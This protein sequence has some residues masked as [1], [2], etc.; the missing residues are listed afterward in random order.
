MSY[1]QFQYLCGFTDVY[2]SGGRAL[3]DISL[4]ARSR[5]TW[6]RPAPVITSSNM[7]SGTGRSGFAVQRDCLQR[8]K[9]SFAGLRLPT[10][11]GINIDTGAITGTLRYPACLRPWS[12]PPALAAPAQRN[13]LPLTSVWL[14]LKSP[15]RSRP[16][17][18]RVHRSPT[19]SRRAT[20]QRPTT[21]PVFPLD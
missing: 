19:T 8:T 9:S 10:G 17:R 14:R 18:H 21:P 12:R 3:R 15:A 2:L 16:M 7:A 6:P 4:Q 1:T 13:R 11:C 5:S 20:C